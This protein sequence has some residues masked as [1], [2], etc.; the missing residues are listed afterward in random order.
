MARQPQTSGDPTNTRSEIEQL[1]S[2][3]L[4]MGRTQNM[5][6]LLVLELCQN[7]LGMDKP[8]LAALAVKNSQQGEPERLFEQAASQG[9]VG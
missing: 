4:G 5:L 9:K 3:L 2:I 8:S 7:Q 1:K 6:T